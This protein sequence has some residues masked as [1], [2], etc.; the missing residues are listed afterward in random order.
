LQIKYNYNMSQNQQAQNQNIEILLSYLIKGIKYWYLPIF[1]TIVGFFIAFYKVRY[2]VPKF[3]A[4]GRIL[5]KT[6][7]LLG[8]KNIL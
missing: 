2:H 5:V 4:S 6:N 3:E 1:A 7:I 8:G